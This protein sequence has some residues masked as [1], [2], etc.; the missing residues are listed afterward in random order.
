MDYCDGDQAMYISPY[1]N[2]D[3]VLHVS[4]NIKASWSLLWQEA[5]D[6]FDVILQKDS[7]LAQFANK[8]FYVW[9]GN[10]QLIAWRRHINKYHS[11][12]KTW[13]IFVDCIVVDPKNCIAIVINDINDIN[14]WV[15]AFFYIVFI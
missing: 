1:N 9:E 3:E 15:L 7:N 11:F 12:D 13:H 14:W 5:N 10:H 2:L 8:T 6:E 4:D